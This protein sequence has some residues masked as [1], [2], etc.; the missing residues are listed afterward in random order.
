MFGRGGGDG[1]GT[2]RLQPFGV[3]GHSEFPISSVLDQF[4]VF[5][6][7]LHRFYY[8]LHRFSAGVGIFTLP[9]PP[10]PRTWGWGG[11]VGHWGVGY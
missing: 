11:G 5:C 6:Y 7:G 4:A 3:P 8:G 9:L 1:G 2:F 10:L